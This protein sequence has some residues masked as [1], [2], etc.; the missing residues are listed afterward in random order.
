MVMK[1]YVIEDYRDVYPDIKGRE[2]TERL[3]KDILD[4]VGVENAEIKRTDS[5]KPY[6]DGDDV[7]FSV[8]HSGNYFVM[9]TGNLPVGVD[10]QKETGTDVGAVSRR[11]FTEE[12]AAIVRSEGRDFFFKL[13]TMKEAY[14]K[15]LGTGLGKVLG[16][17]DVL[18]RE[19]V[20]FAGFQLEK[21]MY[22]TCCMKKQK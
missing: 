4:D 13:W 2:L 6:V 9:L 5:G 21:G 19:D 14:A 11:F 16:E 20:E 10:I 12:E 15:Y 8:S 1:L 22:C 18:N 17:V 3:I 7:F